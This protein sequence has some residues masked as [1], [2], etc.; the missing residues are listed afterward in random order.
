MQPTVARQ[1]F[2]EPKNRLN[3]VGTVFWEQKIATK[4]VGRDFLRSDWQN[5]VSELGIDGRC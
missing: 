1:V 3:V 5:L 2:G 4:H